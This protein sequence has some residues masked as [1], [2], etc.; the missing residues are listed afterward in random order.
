MP[1]YIH[2]ASYNKLIASVNNIA[3]EKKRHDMQE[4]I[5]SFGLSV[6]KGRR[7]VTVNDRQVSLFETILLA[8]HSANKVEL[9]FMAYTLYHADV[10][11]LQTSPEYE[12]DLK[13]LCELGMLE[14]QD[15]KVSLARLALRNKVQNDTSES[16]EEEVVVLSEQT[17]KSKNKKRKSTL[18][19]TASLTQSLQN[20][21][22]TKKPKPV[23]AQPIDYTNVMST[24]TTLE[25]NYL[26]LATSYQTI[27][28][29]YQT[30]QNN[31]SDL[32]LQVQAL[33]EQLN[34]SPPQIIPPPLPLPDNLFRSTST[35]FLFSPLPSGNLQLPLWNCIPSP[36]QGDQQQDHLED[37]QPA[38]QHLSSEQWNLLSSELL[39]LEEELQLR[40]PSP[41]N[42]GYSF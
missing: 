5:Q 3:D 1:I 23:T 6:A 18:S 20:P 28:S 12:N 16:S 9:Y 34:H 33:Q 11:K 37:Q 26:T 2:S 32:Q 31:Y 42:R 30:L 17:D 38:Q 40:S 35:N 19:S 41:L 24:L 13:R 27:Q 29:L 22:V 15:D 14:V 25:T 8:N 21:Q 10:K 39:P 7:P 36:V 4:Q